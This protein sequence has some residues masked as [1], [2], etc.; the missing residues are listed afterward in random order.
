VTG[1]LGRKDEDGFFWYVGR[2]DEVITSG[3]YRIGPAEVEECLIRHPAVAPA[4]VIGVPDPIRTEIVKACVVLRA[5]VEPSDAL[6]RE[7]QDF[8]KVRLAAHEYPREVAFVAELPMTVTG[9]VMRRVL[10]SQGAEEAA[11]ARGE[12]A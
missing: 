9:K 10:R 12:S 2:D 11:A 5:G 7:I 4:A 1:D 8:V 6:A 3:G